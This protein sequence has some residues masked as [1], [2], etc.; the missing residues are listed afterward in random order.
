M[1]GSLIKF[2]VALAVSIG[3]FS[4]A[5]PA[6]AQLARPSG[7]S[8]IA[9][10]PSRIM[11]PAAPHAEVRVFSAGNEFGSRNVDLVNGSV[12][13]I[14]VN[15]S[16]GRFRLRVSS[17]SGG[18]LVAPHLRQA[19]SYSV[20]LRDP[21]GVE[22]VKPMTNGDIVFEGQS[23]TG[24]TCAQGANATIAV[25]STDRDVSAALAGEYF[26]QLLLSVDPL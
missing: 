6:A 14:C 3:S 11:M 19:L 7:P 18:A 5:T 20:I 26:E 8:A 25:R 9:S 16:T 12:A 17:Q 4:L 2:R 15:S 13:S 10:G 24:S 21:S 22:Q 1:N 23:R